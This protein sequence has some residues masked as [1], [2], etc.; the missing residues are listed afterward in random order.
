MISCFYLSEPSLPA[1]G[2]VGVC[3]LTSQDCAEWS[4]TLNWVKPL[5][6]TAVSATK[7]A[8]KETNSSAK[9]R[10][11]QVASHAGQ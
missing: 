9:G 6:T 3:P 11:E 1:A 7:K 5:V 4:L 10:L 2:W 8:Q